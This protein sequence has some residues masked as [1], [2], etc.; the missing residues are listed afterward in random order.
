MLARAWPA[1]LA[2]ALLAVA[3][4]ACSARTAERPEIL[5]L[6][7]AS[8]AD[9]LGE[10]EREFE[11]QG[12]ADVSFSYGGS[13]SL[14]RQIAGG[15]PADVFISAGASPVDYLGER[16]LIEG[17]AAP[18]FG[19]TLVVVARSPDFAPATLAELARLIARTG[20]RIALADPALAPAGQYARQS[21]E[22]LG[23]WDALAGALVFAPD[24]RAALAYARSGDVDAAI[25][26]RTDAQGADGV[27]VLDIVPAV[28]HAPIV[29][30]AAVLRR[31][32]HA[33]HAARF[34]E[35]LRGP[36]AQAIFREHGFETMA[37]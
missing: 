23:L 30:P 10:V 16:N 31:T 6:A 19:N 32:R 26:Y 36:T 17:E 33:E 12:G 24:V 5:A 25:V 4:A 3:L 35:F 8:L 28:S 2:A 9:A 7:A 37:R 15:A 18:L 1:A 34:L 21:L 22:T 29:Y 11:A 14:A 27:Y 13:Q 20:G